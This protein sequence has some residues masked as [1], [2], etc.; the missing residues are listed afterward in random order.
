MIHTLINNL[1]EKIEN[2]N[3]RLNDEEND[4]FNAFNKKSNK[5]FTRDEKYVRNF[6]YNMLLKYKIVDENDKDKKL[7]ILNKYKNDEGKGYNIKNKW[8]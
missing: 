2:E 4:Y 3:I 8:G 7:I 1:K 6:L 5:T